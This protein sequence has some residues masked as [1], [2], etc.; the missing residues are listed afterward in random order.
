MIV[1]E[2]GVKIIKKKKVLQSESAWN[3]NILNVLLCT[4]RMYLSINYNCDKT[5]FSSPKSYEISIQPASISNS[6]YR[7][8]LQ[9]L[10]SDSSG[11]KQFV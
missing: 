5:A 11:F 10:Y 7:K 9:Q 6:L 3:N 4:L 2:I 1:N 8:I